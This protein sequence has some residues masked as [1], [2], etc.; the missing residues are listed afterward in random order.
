MTSDEMQQVFTALGKDLNPFV[1]SIISSGKTPDRSILTRNYPTDRQALFGQILV[2]AI[3]FELNGGRIDVTTHPFCSQTGLGDI[4]VTTR[5]NE[6]DLGDAVF[7]VLHEAGHGLYDQGTD[8]VHFGTPR[9]GFVS[10][11]IHESQSRMWENIVGRSH[12]FWEYALPI[13]KAVFPENLSDVSL[14]AFHWAVNDVQRSFIR[15]EADEATY[16][17]HVLLRFEIEQAIISGNLAVADIPG[18][19]NH[20]M[21]DLLHITPRNDAEGCLQDT[22]WSGGMFGYFPTY[23]LGNL[24]AAQFYEKAAD[25]LGDLD[26]Q[27]ACGRFTGL[28]EWLRTNIHIQGMRYRAR[29]LV[30]HVTGKPLS[31]EPLMRHLRGRLGPQYGV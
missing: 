2:G 24:Y 17:L 29:D 8:P 7:G 27:F 19:W 16:N 30:Q 5:Y 22:H 31:H 26:A 14:D 11:G 1:E 4:R 15:V 18:A 6:R 28:R 10:L 21:Q 20:R 23:T 3:G 13:A 9:G 25:D 12:G